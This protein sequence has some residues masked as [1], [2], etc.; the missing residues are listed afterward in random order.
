MPTGTPWCRVH[1]SYRTSPFRHRLWYALT[2]RQ[3]LTVGRVLPKLREWLCSPIP[4][5][6]ESGWQQATLEVAL[7]N[8]LENPNI[9]V[10]KNP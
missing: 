6:E 3:A 8:A 7:P 2:Q 4:A 9:Q 1:F 5:S 10:H